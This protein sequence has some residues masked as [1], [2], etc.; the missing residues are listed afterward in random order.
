MSAATSTSKVSPTTVT[1]STASSAL[2]RRQ[3]RVGR[4]GTVSGLTR[5]R[6]AIG[7]E[8]SKVLKSQSLP[9]DGFFDPAAPPILSTEL[10]TIDDVVVRQK[11]HWSPT[12]PK[13]MGWWKRSVAGIL[14]WSPDRYNQPLPVEKRNSRDSRRVRKEEKERKR[15]TKKGSKLRGENAS[16][17][18]EFAWMSDPELALDV[19]H[20]P[21]LT[22]RTFDSSTPTSDSPWSVRNDRHNMTPGLSDPQD[23]QVLA[24]LRR[25]NVGMPPR[26][27]HHS[28]EAFRTY[29]PSPAAAGD[30][31]LFT[32]ARRASSWDQGDKAEY[33]VQ[34]I[35]SDAALADTFK[36]SDHLMWRGSEGLYVMDQGVLVP[37]ST[38]VDEGDRVSSGG[39]IGGWKNNHCGSRAGPGPST[40]RYRSSQAAAA[41]A[42]AHGNLQR[43]TPI[44]DDFPS[45]HQHDRDPVDP[46][47][48]SEDELGA[49]A[50]KPHLNDENTENWSEEEEEEEEED[51]ASSDDYALTFSPSGKR[52][53][54]YDDGDDG[55]D[56]ND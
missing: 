52:L 50:A 35:T 53:A 16:F 30:P 17:V 23:E 3:S 27:S 28:E 11:L 25:R 54:Q 46:A 31:N 45:E 15:L 42:A 55:N 22:S 39:S 24:Y 34:S 2:Q 49:A 18:R 13:S 14:S 5:S 56:D 26:P 41:N 32:S 37:V 44:L 38:S 20:D 29:L 21:M 36:V 9:L 4:S 8:S 47:Y 51:D 48:E 40:A 43:L 6:L 7:V 1:T 19:E 33:E 12:E 10:T